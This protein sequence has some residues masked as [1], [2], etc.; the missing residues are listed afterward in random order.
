MITTPLEFQLNSEDYSEAAGQ[1]S[2]G[3]HLGQILAELNEARGNKYVSSD[4]ATKQIYFSMGFI[5]E[6]VLAQVLVD[7]AIKR[8]AGILVRPGEFHLDGIAM[9]PDAID[10]TDYALEEYK[11]TWMSSSNEIDGPKFWVWMKQMQC[12]CKAIG[13]RT[14]R[15][16]V[17]FVVGD[18]KGS[19]PQVKAWQFEFTE[20]EID[21]TW[22]MVTNHAR[23]KG[24]I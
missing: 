20:R 4:E 7:T 18:W 13:T 15:L 3:L 5:W 11:A 16:R 17:F 19:G 24:W 23:S 10:L 2:P 9:S 12:Y 6:Q 1:R 22:Q 8:S 21:E 14:A